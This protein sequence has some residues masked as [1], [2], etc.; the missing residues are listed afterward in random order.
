MILY[1][2]G[3]LISDENITN[4]SY[5]VMFSGGSYAISWHKGFLTSMS[6]KLG[7]CDQ[8]QVFVL[9]SVN[10]SSHMLYKKNNCWAGKMRGIA[11]GIMI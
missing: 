10:R 1:C 8:G 2:N 5:I 4:Y 3:L 7:C 11:R 9:I 6:N